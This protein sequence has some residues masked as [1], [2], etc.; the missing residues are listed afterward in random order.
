MCVPCAADVA[1]SSAD[2]GKQADGRQSE[3]QQPQYEAPTSSADA[4]HIQCGLLDDQVN[5]AASY[6]NDKQELAATDASSKSSVEVR[7]SCTATLLPPIPGMHMLSHRVL[8]HRL[9]TM[10]FELAQ[11]DFNPVNEP[12]ADAREWDGDEP[13]DDTS[14]LDVGLLC[15][16][17][18]G[19]ERWDHNR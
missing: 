10:T 19:K 13:P 2:S 6:D 7:C 8:A 18:T 4:E 1:A 3:A 16:P 5:Q 17:S 15:S 14:F 9:Y 11:D 12:D